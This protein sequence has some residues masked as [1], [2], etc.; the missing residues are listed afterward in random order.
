MNQLVDQQKI[1]ITDQPFS[2]APSY[3][4]FMS[5]IILYFIPLI[6]LLVTLI[7]GFIG[8]INRFAYKMSQNDKKMYIIISPM[9]NF[10]MACFDQST[11]QKPKIFSLLSYETK[12]ILTFEGLEP[13]NV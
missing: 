11:D 2:V 13:E 10:L 6:P 1:E 9:W 8:L 4:C 12:Q 3:R 7:I 5:F